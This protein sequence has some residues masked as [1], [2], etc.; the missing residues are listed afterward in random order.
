[1]KSIS[2]NLNVMIK[3]AEKAS[4]ALIRDFGE[5]ESLQVSTKGPKD[6]VTNADLKAEKIIIKELKKAKP[7]YSIIS[8]EDG[9]EK[10]K[11]KKNTWIIDPIDGTTNFLHGVPHF[12]ISI[13]LKSE[14]EIISGLIYD[15]IKDE[16]FYAEKNNGAFFNNQRIRVSKKKE[17]NACLFAT[18]GKYKNGIDLLTRASGCA[19]LD[20]AYVAAGRYDGYF[21]NSLN[22]WD[23]AAGVI[24]VQ[25]AGG[26][27]NKI[28]LSQNKNIQI[29]ASSIAIN[30]KMLEKLKNF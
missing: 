3:A 18:G 22:L 28:D 8:E 15:P 6:F 16:M 21:Q 26:I 7:N 13:A 9:S 17:L 1:M 14:N 2:A 29:K 24:L 5:I 4:I 30:E 10:N 20:M 19:A 25:E 23:I 12:A 11:D 27:I